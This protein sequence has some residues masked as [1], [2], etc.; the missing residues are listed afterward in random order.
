MISSD[1]ISLILNKYVLGSAAILISLVVAYF[2]GH[3]AASRAAE[4]ARILAQAALQSKLRA[5]EAK[6]QFLEKK[7]EKTDEIINS[8]GSIDEL[9]SLWNQIQSGKSPGSSSDQNAK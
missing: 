3:A 7:G 8:A 2:K 5:A 1:I 6:N 4:E 9:I